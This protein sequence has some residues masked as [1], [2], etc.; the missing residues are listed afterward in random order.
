LDNEVKKLVT[1]LDRLDMKYREFQG[2]IEAHQEHLGTL[3]RETTTIESYSQVL[4]TRIQN[5]NKLLECHHMMLSGVELTLQEKKLLSDPP[6]DSEDGIK[7]C[8]D[9]LEKISSFLRI[10]SD[11]TTM[12]RAVREQFQK[13]QS[14]LQTFSTKFKDH[15]KK[16]SKLLFVER[17]K[18]GEGDSDTGFKLADTQYF[19]KMLMQLRRTLILLFDCLPEQRK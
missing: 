6:L 4:D 15:L 17:R 10:S 12:I 9:V 14:G 2:F 13:I 3:T 1:S 11:Q 5:Q 7:A 8:E 18:S 16:Q 19:R